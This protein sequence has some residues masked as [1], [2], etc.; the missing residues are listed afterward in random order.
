MLP[1]EGRGVVA[2]WDD[3]LRYLTVLTATQMPYIAQTGLGE[4]LGLSDGAGRVI[5][6]DASNSDLLDVTEI[7]G[8]IG[9]VLADPHAPL[10]DEMTGRDRQII[11]RRYV[12]E[13]AAGEV[14][15]AVTL[16]AR[17]HGVE[18]LFS[19]GD[20]FRPQI[21]RFSLGGV[22]LVAQPHIG[23]PMHAARL[24]RKRLQRVVT[25]AKPHLDHLRSAPCAC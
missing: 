15:R 2:W 14:F 18:K 10:A 12:F 20:R 7:P 16:S 11:R 23:S 1:L 24:L 8:H 22:G 6:P 19:S 17:R 25:P 21:L 4:C 9:R 5:S 13:D 3:R